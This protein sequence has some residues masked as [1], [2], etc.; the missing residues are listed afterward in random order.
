MVRFGNSFLIVTPTSQMFVKHF[1]KIYYD[2]L[3]TGT[4]QKGLKEFKII[5]I[6]DIIIIQ[7]S[8]IQDIIIQTTST[9]R[10]SSSRQH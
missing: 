9:S 5:N 6:Q 10:T 7:D 1:L 3:I 8:I 2:C 4:S